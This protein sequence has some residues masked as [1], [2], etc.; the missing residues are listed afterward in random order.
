MAEANVNE[1]VDGRLCTGCGTCVIAC[2]TDAI[3]MHENAAGF[4]RPRIQLDRC[5]H[6]G[7]CLSVCSGRQYRFDLPD[8]LDGLFAPQ[9]RRAMLAY[10]ADPAVHAQGQS[11]GFITALITHLLS[12]GQITHAL[13]T[14]VSADGSCRPE[15][16]FATTAEEVLSAAGSKYCMT[17]LVAAVRDWPSKD[18]RVAVVG[19]PCHMHGLY[20]LESRYPEQWANRFVLKVGLFCLQA[21]GTLSIDHFLTRAR[22][23]KQVLRIRWRAKCRAGQRGR[24]CIEYTDGSY[25]MFPEDCL[26]D[27][28]NS[29]LVPLRCSICFD[30][31]NRLSD[32]SVGDPNGYPASVVAKGRSAVAVYTQRGLDAIERARQDGA[33]AIEDSEPKQLWQGQGVRLHRRQRVLVAASWFRRTGRAMPPVEALSNASSRVGF[34]TRLTLRYL[35]GQEAVGDRD[36]AYGR[37]MRARRA[38]GLYARLRGLILK[39]LRPAAK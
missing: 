32:V 6:C 9:P 12:S 14:R 18:A 21:A 29:V 30:Q 15:P 13:L 23:D 3:S 16:F 36:R 31:A 25:E 24:P 7:Q 38:L 19:L 5:T 4:P 35:W 33:I 27:F 20:N 17:P 1:V 22:P 10:A 11:G 26:W 34:A 28:Y 39:L 2:P 8:D 37:S